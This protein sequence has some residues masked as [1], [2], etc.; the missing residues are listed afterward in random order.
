MALDVEAV[1]AALFA[2]LQAQVTGVAFS[3]RILFSLENLSAAQ[4]PAMLVVSQRAQSQNDNVHQQLWRLSS[5]VILY[6]Q[7][8][9]GVVPE[10]VLFGLIKLVETALQH[11][12]TEPNYDAAAATSLGGL[13]RYARLIDHEIHHGAGNRLAAATLTVEMLASE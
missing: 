11:Q 5:L 4:R 6:V 3:S 8:E 7:V 12:N 10:T 1:Q 2:R 9:Q 13:V